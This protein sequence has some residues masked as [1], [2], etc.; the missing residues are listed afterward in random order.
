MCTLT[1]PSS[2][3]LE[4]GHPSPKVL[5]KSCLSQKLLTGELFTGHGYPCAS[6]TK[7]DNTP[8]KKTARSGAAVTE[9]PAGRSGRILSSPQCISGSQF[10]VKM[11]LSLPNP[12]ITNKQNFKAKQRC[13]DGVMNEFVSWCRHL[14]V[15]FLFHALTSLHPPSFH[16]NDFS[17]C[18]SYIDHMDS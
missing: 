13:R 6:P 2:P 8:L 4:R 12:F 17:T 18:T 14:L 7:R 15:P 10:D 9:V 1:Y 5:G 11:F 16:R 3:P